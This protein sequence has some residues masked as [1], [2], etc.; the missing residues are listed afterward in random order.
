MQPEPPMM[1]IPRKRW[2]TVLVI[3]AA[4]VGVSAW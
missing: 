3:I 1:R 4:V 2:I